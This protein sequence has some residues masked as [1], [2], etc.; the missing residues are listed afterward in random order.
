MVSTFPSITCVCHF[1]TDSR[2]NKQDYVK[3]AASQMN[4]ALGD[5][6]RSYVVGYGKNPPVRPHHAA[7][8]CPLDD[9][10]TLNIYIFEYK[11]CR[12]KFNNSLSN[13]QEN[14][15][16]SNLQPLSSLD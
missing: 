5:G 6:G 10:G 7:A 16:L 14:Y 8:S 2:I 15:G 3:F 13:Y 9:K 12:A 4:Y 11:K 1:E